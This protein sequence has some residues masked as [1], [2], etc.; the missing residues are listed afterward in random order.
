MS[1]AVIDYAGRMARWEPGAAQRLQQAALELFA[2]RG[3]EQTTVADIA[4]AAG[5]TERTFFRHFGDKREV[6][7]HGQDEFVQMFLD[8]MKAAPDDATA[9]E[10]VAAAIA[11][12]ASFFPEQ[13]RPHSRMRQMIIDTNP[14]LQER[15]RH[16]LASLA[17][18]IAA[19]LRE[20]DVP[21]PAATLAAESAATVFGIAFGQWISEGE[22]RSLNSI[23]SY[24]LAELRALSG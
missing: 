9:M 8:G 17:V 23:T 18:T 5:L 21:E 7:F 13:R 10:L 3:F 22:R 14:A 16:K 11:G 15:E 2:S 19:A 20:R 4:E 6:L 1:V 24:V 12:A